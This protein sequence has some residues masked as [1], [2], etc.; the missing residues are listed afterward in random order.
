MKIAIFSATNIL[1][2]FI[3]ATS[4]TPRYHSA[5]GSVESNTDY[6]FAGRIVDETISAL[7]ASAV[8]DA[9]FRR[10]MRHRPDNTRALL[11]LAAAL[12]GEKPSLGRQLY[13]D[14]H[15]HQFAVQQVAADFAEL[16]SEITQL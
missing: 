5:M 13:I 8:Y 15:V 14:R 12:F 7:G 11:L 16:T 6:E 1:V 2:I 3:T 4:A 9:A 10:E